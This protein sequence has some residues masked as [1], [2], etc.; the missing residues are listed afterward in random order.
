M[1]SEDL[2]PRRNRSTTL[3]LACPELWSDDQSVTTESCL[4]K[5]EACVSWDELSDV[6]AL[7]S[8]R[9]HSFAVACP[10]HGIMLGLSGARRPLRLRGYE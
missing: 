7:Q 4:A 9:N 2:S 8:S 3:K 10:S 5:P 1:Q 6:E